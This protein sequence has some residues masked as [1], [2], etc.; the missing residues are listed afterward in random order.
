MLAMSYAQLI[1]GIAA[2]LIVCA[3]MLW[4]PMLRDLL[5]AVAAAGI[6]DLLLGNHSPQGVDSAV[7]RIASAISTH[8]Y[9]TLGLIMAATGAATLYRVRQSQ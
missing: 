1:A 3:L 5:A 8:P 4:T 9:F 2:G 7:E 6:A